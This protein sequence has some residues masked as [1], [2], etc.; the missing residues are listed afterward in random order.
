MRQKK[1]RRLVED[2]PATVESQVTN[3][4][5]DQ[6]R[7]YCVAEEDSMRDRAADN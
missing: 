3:K 2:T 5:N 7:D 1:D 6:K 4:D